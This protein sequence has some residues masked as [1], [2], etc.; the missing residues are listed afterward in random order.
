MTTGCKWEMDGGET[1]LPTMATD[2]QGMAGSCWSLDM[3]DGALMEVEVKVREL[4]CQ[5]GGHS[6]KRKDSPEEQG[7]QGPCG[8]SPGVILAWVGLPPTRYRGERSR[9]KPGR[10][11]SD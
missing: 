4:A 9:S 2:G 10:L 11:G 6:L 3:M 1:G 7:T 5:A 8:P